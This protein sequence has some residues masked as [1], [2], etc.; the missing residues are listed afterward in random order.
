MQ[1]IRK[2]CFGNSNNRTTTTTTTTNN[3]NN[4]FDSVCGAVVVMTLLPQVISRVDP[5]H[6]MNV[7]QHQ[8]AANCQT[9]PTDLG[10][11]SA[12]RLLFIPNIKRFSWSQVNLDSD[13]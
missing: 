9:K 6:L 10:C 13:C 2:Y 7:E 12:C 5:V 11:E 3:N 4:N 1:H 8:V